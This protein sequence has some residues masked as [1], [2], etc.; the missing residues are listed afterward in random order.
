MHD[1]LAEY[2]P[3]ADYFLAMAI[4]RAI[5]PQPLRL[6]P[7]RWEKLYL[8]QELTLRVTPKH[9][10][11][12]LHEKGIGNGWWHEFFTAPVD[13]DDLLLY[14]LTS[15]LSWGEASKRVEK[16]Y[17]ADDLYRNELGV[18]LAFST[19]T[20][21]PAVVDVFW[22]AIKNITTFKEFLDVFDPENVTFIIDRWLYN[23]IL[24]DRLNEEGI[25]CVIPSCKNVG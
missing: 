1:L 15:V 3:Y 16:G 23:E 18:I 20:N 5:D 22:R 4:I 12:V 6:H 11:N 7:S 17:K 25:G 14:D 8:S 19:A 9:L 2:T 13:D 21:L 10:S 24:L